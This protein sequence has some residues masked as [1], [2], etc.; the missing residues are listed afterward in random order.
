MLA[1]LLA[2]RGL[3][4]SEAR[5]FLASDNEISW[6]SPFAFRQMRQAVDLIVAQ[7]KEQNLIAIVG[8]YDADGVTSSAVLWETLTTL[9][10]KVQVWIPNR[11][12]EGYGLNQRLI[13]DIKAAGCSLMIT[14]DNGIRSYEEVAYA[15]QQGLTVIVTDHHTQ[16]ESR[17][18]L[19]EA[20]IIN[21][22]LEQETY[23]FKF[24]AG[25][26]VAFKLAAAL[27]EASSLS[28]NIKERLTKRILDLVAIGTI[29]DCVSL[30]GE[31]R[32]LVRQGLRELNRRE[33]IGI[34]AL[35][36]VA[37]IAS[38]L[39]ESNVSWQIA[40][41]LNVAGR[42]GRANAAYE[43][44]VT[45]DQAEAVKLAEEL[46]DKNIHRQAETQ[47]LVEYA[48]KL[49]E[50]ELLLD[51]ILII[52]APGLRGESEEVWHE[53]IIGLVAGKICERYSRPAFVITASEGKIKGSGRSVEGYNIVALLERLKQ[54]L[55]RFGG[56]KAACGFT[57]KDQANFDKFAQELRRIGQEEITD[58]FLVP[59]LKI[60]AELDLETVD[61]SLVEEIK[62]FA[63]FGQGNREPVFV[64]R[65]VPV[66][67]IVMMGADSQH[68]K[69]KF[70]NFW[71][72]A[73]G[74]AVK[75][76]ALKLGDKID[77]VY[78]LEFNDFN[79]FRNVQMRIIDMKESLV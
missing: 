2:N 30:L 41:R 1:Q 38:D 33:R 23:P 34:D 35:V 42:L 46:N 76:Q 59:T 68:I 6:H 44:L 53:G 36:K 17:A 58:D 11:L 40:P 45:T 50:K 56:H 47:R 10:A 7:I 60:D 49:V 14:V 18:D 8:D 77:V 20:I 62:R 43:I 51:K 70:H 15:R 5:S 75:W 16:D 21:P 78:T 12:S 31:N 65:A 29:A 52:S 79:G 32:F 37:Q 24:L 69:F 73:F 55:E 3:N 67:D 27:I 26:G 28:A 22:V 71:A 64:S 25:V 61:K 74:E 54:Y 66:K 72:I 39:N 9:K 19:P 48:T 13:K 63:P 57:V 4:P